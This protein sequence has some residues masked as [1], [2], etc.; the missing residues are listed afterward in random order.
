MQMQTAPDTHLDH[1]ELLH[2]A[3]IDMKAGRHDGAIDKL[4]RALTLMPDDANV[5]FMLGAEHAE[6]GLFDRAA[7]EMERSIGLN[8]D[9][10]IARFQLGLVHYRQG[11]I[12]QAKDAWHPLE[13]LGSDNSLFLFKSAFLKIQEEALPDAIM[14]L[15]QSLAAEANNAALR[16]EIEKVLSNVR[17]HL[18]KKEPEPPTEAT[19]HLFAHRYDDAARGPN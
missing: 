14:L 16:R 4:K 6:I 5:L 17:E 18:G 10:H 11:R 3:L 1:D 2:L 13:K 19:G 12:T 7:E 15:E 9:L 8:P